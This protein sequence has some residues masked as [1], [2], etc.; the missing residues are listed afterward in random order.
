MPLRGIERGSGSHYASKWLIRLRR[1]LLG[2]PIPQHVHLEHRLPIYL[3]LAVFA[4]D[5]F[6]SVAYAT[7]E[8]LHVLAAHHGPNG[9]P[10]TNYLI[11][12]S[13]GICV[14]MV[15][16]VASYMRAVQIYPQGGGSYSVSRSNLGYRA[17]L[18]AAAAL[19]IDYI[20]TVAVSASAG[21][22][23]FLSMFQG[24]RDEKVLITVLL[25]TFLTLLNLRGTK[26]SAAIIAPF[27]YGFVAL[28]FTL[29][30]AS[31]WHAAQGTV[32]AVPPH[33]A[34]EA[35]T[36]GLL[37][38]IVARAFSN[39]CAA[40]TGTETISIGV[41][42]FKPPEGKHAAQALLIMVCLSVMMFLGISISASIYHVTPS[43]TETVVSQ[44]ARANFAGTPVAFLFPMVIFATI[45]ILMIAANGAFAGLPRLLAMVARDGFAPR[46]LMEQGDRLVFNRGIAAL[47]VISIGI[48][49]MFKASVNALIPLYAVGVFICFTLSQFAFA[50]K[51]S[52][53]PQRRWG[54]LLLL[55]VGGVATGVVA[56]TIMIS[57]FVDGAWLVVLLIPLLFGMGLLIRRHY[58]WFRKRMMIMPK[59]IN[60]LAR[61]AEPLTIV[62]LVGS[63]INRGTLEGI[64]FARAVAEG[65]S[66]AIIRALH[67]EMDKD[68]TPRL[69]KQ[70]EEL[71]L[72]HVK[73][74]IKLEFTPSPYRWLIL[75]IL[76][77]LDKL[78]KERYGDQIIVVI[79][80]FETGNWFT[81]FL[82]NATSWRL[83]QALMG[84]PHITIVT[85]RY[86]LAEDPEADY[87]PR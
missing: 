69:R 18:L 47:A 36:G 38:L 8:I 49:I 20:M 79:P 24:L 42:A 33:P 85:T 78:E 2:S 12:V 68:R 87:K 41:T 22:E 51:L 53:E 62:L 43:P 17:G 32:A 46:S 54:S 66:N 27:C 9:E 1:M 63:E 15:V 64:E 35:T 55:G 45:F 4:S 31:L 40:L 81:H 76:Q 21:V 77:Y 5:P 23:A 14:L 19:T 56:L 7:E 28:M 3:A 65:K 73:S 86:F 6:S 11:P 37:W 71:V 52:K 39:G 80:E 58:D 10:L 13:I 75:P 26:E 25:I 48:V 72:K 44:L 74:K 16:V 83:R 57:K 30:G 34:V 82:H 61:Q 67:V 59:D 60:P 70:W 84:R 29:I 50:I